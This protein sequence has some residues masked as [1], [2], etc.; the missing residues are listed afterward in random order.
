MRDNV[1][2]GVRISTWL[3]LEDILMA[4]TYLAITHGPKLSLL[5]TWKLPCVS[6]WVSCEECDDRLAEYGALCNLAAK[7]RQRRG[8]GRPGFQHANRTIL[9][10][11][12]Q[13]VQ[14]H[15]R[16]FCRDA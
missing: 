9:G 14:R 13:W 10:F 5:F 2:H 15:P 6:P 4:G 7:L 8:G 12:Y 1:S 11:C 3:R 16:F